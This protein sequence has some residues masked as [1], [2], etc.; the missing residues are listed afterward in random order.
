MHGQTKVNSSFLVFFSVLV[1]IYRCCRHCLLFFS[2]LLWNQGTWTWEFED[3]VLRPSDHEVNPRPSADKEKM[4]LP[5]WIHKCWTRASWDM[6]VM[7]WG[8]GP[9][10]HTDSECVPRDHCVHCAA[11]AWNCLRKTRAQG[12]NYSSAGAVVECK[13]PKL[14][15]KAYRGLELQIDWSI[16]WTLDGAEWSASGLVRFNPCIQWIEQRREKFVPP[17]DVGNWTPI[18]P[19]SVRSIVSVTIIGYNL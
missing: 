14:V 9:L 10:V 15:M 12:S 5:G 18:L 16:I 11:T 6:R 3:F 7:C 17:P 8:S 2:N 4:W 1:D 19:S 13:V